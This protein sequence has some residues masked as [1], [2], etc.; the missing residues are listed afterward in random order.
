[1]HQSVLLDH[2]RGHVLALLDRAVLGLGVGR[3]VGRDLRRG[4][5]L[6]VGSARGNA[7]RGLAVEEV[8]RHV[9]Q[10]RAAG[11]ALRVAVRVVAAV[12]EDGVLVPRPVLRL[13]RTG[14]RQVD[15]FHLDALVEL[16]HLGQLH[17]VRV[18]LLA[19]EIAVVAQTNAPDARRLAEETEGCRLLVVLVS[20]YAGLGALGQF[21]FAPRDVPGEPLAVPELRHAAAPGHIFKILLGLQGV[22]RLDRRQGL[23]V[24]PPLVGV[25]VA[26]V[27][28]AAPRLTGLRGRAPAVKVLRREGAGLQI[29]RVASIPQRVL[30]S[31]ADL[32]RVPSQ[33]SSDADGAGPR[34]LVARDDLALVHLTEGVHVL[35]ALEL[36][37]HD[38]V[39]EKP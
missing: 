37:V 17:Q 7:V 12:A 36:A 26:V 27:E 28:A 18:R 4:R 20:Q 22:D 9:V 35:A 3:D 32:R 31:R 38:L 16:V 6:A 25:R 39:G 21:E 15:V 13:A 1:M 34:V 5:G 8:G 30:P 23:A 11:A 33:S 2:A 19:L 29:A 10:V 24:R 14:R